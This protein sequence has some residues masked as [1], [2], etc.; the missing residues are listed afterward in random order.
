M[1]SAGRVYVVAGTLLVFFV[2]WASI[3]ANPWAAARPD[4]QVAALA[5]REAAIRKQAAAAQRAYTVRWARY[6]ADLA[7][8]RALQA[9]V[10]TAP[11]P[12]VRIV[13]LPPVATTRTS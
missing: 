10:T 6:R 3:A 1:T 8:R 9:A 7:Q 11:A 2:L 13:Q 5:H 4:P 12:Q